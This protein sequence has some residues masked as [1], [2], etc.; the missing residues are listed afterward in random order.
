M[1]K[2]PKEAYDKGYRDGRARAE[3]EKNNTTLGTALSDLLGGPSHW[4]PDKD[5]PNTYKEGREQG[6]KDGL[7]KK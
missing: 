6:R 3:S 7:K 5:F 2:D 4:H 1:A